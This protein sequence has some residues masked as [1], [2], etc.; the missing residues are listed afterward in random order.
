M[1]LKAVPTTLR[2]ANAFVAAHHR[3]NLPPRGHRFSIGCVSEG[4]PVGV[5]IVGRPV[6][7]NFDPAEVAEVVRVCVLDNAPL[8]TCS[9]LYGAC[10]RAWREMGGKKMITY[11]LQQESGSSMRGAGWLK[12][13]EIDAR[14]AGGWTNRGKGRLAQDVVSQ[15][16]IRWEIQRT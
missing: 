14:D 5:A 10:W 15:P 7:R 2:A 9:F 6:S 3:H 8:G 1:T 12:A 11:T 4:R 13:A 16:K